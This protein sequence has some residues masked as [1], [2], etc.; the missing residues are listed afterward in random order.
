MILHGPRDGMTEAERDAHDDALMAAAVLREA[1]ANRLQLRASV[2]SAF[3]REL[4]REAQATAWD[5]GYVCGADDQKTWNSG[6]LGFKGAQD[7]PYRAHQS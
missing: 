7:N 5:A 3:Q 6:V 2:S 4:F 1:E